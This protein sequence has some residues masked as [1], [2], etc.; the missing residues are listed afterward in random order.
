MEDLEDVN[1]DLAPSVPSYSGIDLLLRDNLLKQQQDF[2][3][4]YK[5]FYTLLTGQREVEDEDGN[6]VWIQPRGAEKLFEER[7]AIQLLHFYKGVVN[8]HLI[9]S[10]VK[11]NEIRRILG[12]LCDSILELIYLNFD[13]W[14]SE[15]LKAKPHGFEYAVKVVTDFIL[16]ST[17]LALNRALNGEERKSSREKTAYSIV[18]SK[19]PDQ[20]RRFL[21]LQS[22]F[23]MGGGNQ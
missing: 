15:E 10:Y 21:G 23:N 22:I 4:L 5:S 8:I 12:H 16:I 11:E 9:N 1:Q 7:G 20:K 18:E 13:D 14:A 3:E 19:T 6:I 2:S 17:H